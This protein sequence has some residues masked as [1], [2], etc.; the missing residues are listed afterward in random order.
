VTL[1]AI[2]VAPLWQERDGSLTVGLEQRGD[3]PAVV[4]WVN[5]AYIR[6][7]GEPRWFLLTMDIDR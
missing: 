6:I 7:N 1:L 4:G 2:H 3:H 5:A